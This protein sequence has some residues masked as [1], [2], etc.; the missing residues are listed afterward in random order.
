MMNLLEVSFWGWAEPTSIIYSRMMP[1]KTLRFR[2]KNNSKPGTNAEE[3]L[4][5]ENS[6]P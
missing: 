1:E 3:I 5:L 6:E 4:T 2:G